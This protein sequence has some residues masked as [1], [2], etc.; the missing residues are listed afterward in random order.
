MDYE[1]RRM[2]AFGALRW[3]FCKRLILA[4]GLYLEESA[5]FFDRVAFRR[6]TPLAFKDIVAQIDAEIARPQQ[7][8][9]LLAATSV[10]VAFSNARRGRPKLNSVATVPSKPTKKRKRRNLS[11]EGR[12]RIAEASKRRWAKHKAKIKQNGKT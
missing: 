4:V 5:V 3:R 10:S 9:T 1:L 12:A 8:R 2:D 6:E 7:A 11:P